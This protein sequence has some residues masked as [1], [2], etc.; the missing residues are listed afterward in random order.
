MKE[1]S[2]PKLILEKKFSTFATKI[3]PQKRVILAFLTNQVSHQ[4]F[5]GKSRRFESSFRLIFPFF[6]YWE[7][8]SWNEMNYKKDNRT[9][10]A[11]IAKQ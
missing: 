3:L 4:Y 2:L 6:F 9:A 10:F 8:K 1:K 11:W 5:A 7:A